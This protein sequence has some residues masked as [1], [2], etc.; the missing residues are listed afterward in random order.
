[1]SKRKYKPY[2]T[3]KQK[4][5]RRTF[6]I[7]MILI[8]L[9]VGFVVL[10]KMYKGKD[11]P[12]P[13]QDP[14]TS[15]Q[16]LLTDILPDSGDNSDTSEPAEP[17]QPE[18]V[19]LQP[20]PPV[21]T[22]TE[23]VTPP[24]ADTPETATTI[25]GD[26][27]TEEARELVR[28]AIDLDKAGKIIATRDLLNEALDK[29]LSSQL[30]A[31]VKTR[32]TKL[33]D[34]WLFSRDVYESDNFTEYYLV[35]PGETL[36][37]IAQR[38]K[39]PYQILMEING[40]DRAT[41]LQAGQKIK[42]IKGP[43]NAVVYKGSFTI[44]LLLQHTYV[45]TYRVGTGKDGHD[46]PAGHWRVKPGGKSDKKPAWTDPDTGRVYSGSDPDYPLGSR[47]I[48]IEG[49]DDKTRDRTGFAIHGTKDPESIGTRSSRGCIRLYNGDVVEV[50]NMLR[51]GVSE[52]VIF[53]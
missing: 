37:G 41:N 25:D 35:Q 33:A 13:A 14:G 4:K 52:V 42:V 32:M 45:R 7:A 11:E 26:E 16:R 1:M 44:D 3:N 49:L 53:D 10:T 8:V 46:T 23:S 17:T 34:K 47:W 9:I 20:E 39:V 28:Q 30:R 18:P 15:E 36:S 2:R 5:Q 43:F 29:Q 40:I 24:V 31:Q 12:V 21:E 51:E 48:A 22:P 50:Y 6:N 19:A 38:Y 27:S